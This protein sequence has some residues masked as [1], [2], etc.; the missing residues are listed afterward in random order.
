MRVSSLGIGAGT[1]QGSFMGDCMAPDFRQWF[2]SPI[3][4]FVDS[5]EYQGSYW[6]IGDVFFDQNINV[7]SLGAA[8]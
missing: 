1:A 6:P 4:L 8:S 2:V 3:E 5:V 7:G